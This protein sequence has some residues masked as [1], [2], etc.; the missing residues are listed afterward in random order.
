MNKT[1]FFHD[2]GLT[3]YRDAWQFQRL[4]FERII[5]RKR[6]NRAQGAST[7]TENHLLL[8]E[9]SPVYTLGKHG[10]AAHLLFPQ[11][12][13]SEEGIG[14]YHTDRGGDITFHG[15]G[16][17]VAYPILD[18]DNFIPNLHLHVHRM[19]ETVIRTLAD[20]NVP[21]ARVAGRSGV[22]I[23]PGTPWARKICAVGVRSSRGATM[24]GLALNVNTDLE[25]FARIVPC[26][27]SDSGVTSLAHE[28]G[29]TLDMNT[30]GKT[31]LRH[32]AQVFD[33]QIVPAPRADSDG[34]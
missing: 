11:E 2:L 16:Q 22:W 34:I 21:A 10:K 13:L 29:Q 33:C 1:V 7:P 14:F 8:T 31:L 6:D 17:I 25:Y 32:F 24:H 18:L 9:H 15:P 3:D 27:I 23:D 4:L 19:E 5:A 26:G 30:I 12:R 28:K 20:Y